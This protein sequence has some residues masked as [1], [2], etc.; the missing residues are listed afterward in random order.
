[1]FCFQAYNQIDVYFQFKTLET[2]GLILYNAGK[3]DDFLAIE[4]VAGHIQ[5]TFN[6][7]YV[8]GTRRQEL[9]DHALCQLGLRHER[10][11]Q[12]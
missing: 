11:C 4:L 12:Q 10:L 9:R 7:G 2:E 1:M 8:S 3:D 5:Y 6:M